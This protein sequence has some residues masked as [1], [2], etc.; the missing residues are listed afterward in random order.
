MQREEEGQEKE[1]GETQRERVSKPQ[2]GEEAQ[3]GTGP[4]L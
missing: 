2:R 4:C 1:G 3:A